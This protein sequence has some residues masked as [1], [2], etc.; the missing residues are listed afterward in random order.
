M[1]K[2]IALNNEPLLMCYTYLAN[3]F[4]VIPFNP[5]NDIPIFHARDMKWHF[6]DHATNNCTTITNNVIVKQDSSHTY[7]MRNKYSPKMYCDKP[8][9]YAN[10]K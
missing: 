1:T 9:S 3:M 5:E 2:Q 4:S 8:R 7:V 6:S 10:R